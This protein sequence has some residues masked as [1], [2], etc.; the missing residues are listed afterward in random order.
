[1][2]L[3]E[4]L[5][6]SLPNG[7]SASTFISNPKE[8]G[9]IVVGEDRRITVPAELR[10]IAITGDKDIETVTIDCIRYWDG[11]DLSTFAIYLNYLLPN[12]NDGSYIPQNLRV[13]ENQF[14]FDWTIERHMTEVAGAITISIGAIKTD[15]DGTLLKQWGSFPN[16]DMIVSAGLPISNIV[17]EEEKKDV[18]SQIVSSLQQKVDKSNIVQETGYASD[19][20][21]SQYATTNLINKIDDR[22]VLAE[23]RLENIEFSL[24]GQYFVDKTDGIVPANSAPN[25]RVIKV[26]GMTY[27]DEETNTLKYAKPTSIES[28]GANLIPFPYSYT[29]GT[30]ADVSVTIG[31]DGGITMNGTGSKGTDLRLFYSPEN[32]LVLNGTYTISSSAP[33]P[34]GS[35]IYLY[36][37]DTGANETILKQGKSEATVTLNGRYNSIRMWIASGT[38]YDNITFYPMLN[39]GGV[40][41]PY[42]LYREDAVDTLE[43]PEAVQALDGYGQSNL[44]NKEEYNYIDWGRRLFVAFGHIVDGEW[45]AFETMQEIDISDLLPEDNFI[46]V[47]GGGTIV[48]VNAESLDAP[49]EMRYQ[50]KVV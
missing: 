5:L 3:A 13:S 45:V 8:E 12:K 16:S 11:H 31:E 7:E 34:T 14:S 39:A 49:T 17:D 18:L 9:H 15:E 24:S 19:K 30:V 43:I 26:G 36:N 32:P 42:K 4:N 35:S 21:M 2:S 37:V 10:N 41:A 22:F 38:V 25:A 1:M 44:D 40:A 29:G 48:A 27:R 23:K 6:N 28:R 47:E 50:L 20:I 33:M 46:E